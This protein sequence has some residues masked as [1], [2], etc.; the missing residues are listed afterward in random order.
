MPPV[1]RY[2]IVFSL[3]LSLTGT[4]IYAKE[5]DAPGTTKNTNTPTSSAKGLLMLPRT[6]QRLKDHQA[7]RVVCYG[8]SISEVGRSPQWHGGATTP[9]ANWGQQLGV[10][11]HAAYPGSEITVLNF[12][13][14]G[15]NAYEGLGRLD[16]LGPLKPDLVLLEFGAN[17]CC[18]HFLQPAETRLALATLA[19]WT[20]ERYGADVMIVGCGGDNPLDPFFVHL[21]DTLTASRQAAADA[22]VPFVDMRAAVLQATDGGKRWTDFHN[23]AKNCH[24]NDRGHRVW[25][26]TVLTAINQCILAQ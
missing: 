16:A 9:A 5:G 4:A 21:D 26:E 11:L 20:K 3:L 15:Q 17:D 18:Y 12:G 1:N 13:I 19:Q 7:L 6:A 24:P 10:L 8:D 22:G 14:G 23:G 2:L 25:A